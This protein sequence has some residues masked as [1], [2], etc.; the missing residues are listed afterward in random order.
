MKQTLFF[1]AAAM[2]AVLGFT[3]CS[4][5]NDPKMPN[6]D[7]PELSNGVYVICEGN[8]TA[9]IPGSL[10]YI[11]YTTSTASQEVFRTANGR[12]LGDTPQTGIVYGSHVFIGVSQSNTIEILNA[13]TLKSVKQ[14]SLANATGQQP[15]SM[16]A[17]E[18]KVYISMFNGYVSRLDTLTMEIDN[19]VE[20]GPNPEIMAIVGNNLYVPN[21]NGMSMT[22]FGTTASIIGLDNFTVTKTITVPLN[23]TKFATDGNRLWLMCN[24]DYYKIDPGVYSIDLNTYEA[25]NIG[26]GN[27]M[28]VNGSKVYII[29]TNYSTMTT[30]CTVYDTTTGKSSPMLAQKCA[31]WPRNVE[32]D[33]M[34]GDII[35]TSNPIISYSPEIQI[36]DYYSDGIIS[37][38]D[39]KGNL[40]KEYA[41]GISPNCIFFNLH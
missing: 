12:V 23:P 5:D 40:K 6:A 16:V 37:V 2:I 39:S 28:S 30:T 32:V 31:G 36:P 8:Q 18:G 20:V 13:S 1:K 34:T 35:I 26:T 4:D 41:A 25:K 29:H 27:I 22:G 11:D 21:S 9:G 3:A 14:I 7:M 10:T 38:Y 24:G 17:K 33:P 15:R 19:T